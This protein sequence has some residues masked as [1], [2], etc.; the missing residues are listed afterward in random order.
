M[1]LIPEGND[2]E[3]PTK[4]SC[5]DLEEEI[6]KFEDVQ[7]TISVSRETLFTRWP[8]KRAVGLGIA[9]RNKTIPEQTLVDLRRKFR[10]RLVKFFDDQK[11]LHTEY[12]WMMSHGNLE[13]ATILIDRHVEIQDQLTA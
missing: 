6:W 13:V 11:H 9:K 3:S 7:V 12:P 8:Y 2:Y 4:I 10:Q 5:T 1:E